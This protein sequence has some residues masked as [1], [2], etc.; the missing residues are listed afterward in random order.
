MSNC[1]IQLYY[2]IKVKKGIYLDFKSTSF[3]KAVVTYRLFIPL[4]PN[5]QI[6][7]STMTLF[8]KSNNG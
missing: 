1:T 7:S 3:I 6:W 5:S 4:P 2:I 8:N